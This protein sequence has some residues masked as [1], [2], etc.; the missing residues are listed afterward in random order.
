MP[1]FNKKKFK[2]RPEIK[3]FIECE[4]DWI[5]ETE[6][7]ATNIEEGPQGEDI[8]TFICPKCK[9]THRSRRIS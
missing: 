9:R 8:L 1:K 3:V 2:Y 5:P 6:V 4:K 7:E